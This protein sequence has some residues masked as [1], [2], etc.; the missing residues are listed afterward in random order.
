MKRKSIFNE[1]KK[2]NVADTS[3]QFANGR[4]KEKVAARHAHV[5]KKR[6]VLAFVAFPQIAPLA[7]R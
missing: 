4:E 1:I 2:E 5:G 3:T 6:R 7:R